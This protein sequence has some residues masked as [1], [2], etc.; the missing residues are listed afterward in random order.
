M[1][2][3]KTPELE[4]AEKFKFLY[5]K[6]DDLED[7]IEKLDKRLDS[8]EIRQDRLYADTSAVF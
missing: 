7:Q 8:L 5:K 4:I 6:I 2:V 1:K 3:V